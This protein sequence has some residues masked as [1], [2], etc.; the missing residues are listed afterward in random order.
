MYKTHAIIE[1]DSAKRNR[2]D[3]NN[4]GIILSKNIKFNPERQY[5]VRTENARI[6]ISFYAFNSTNNVFQVEE[7]NGATQTIITATVP[8]G[9]YTIGEL[10]LEVENQLDA[11]T[12]QTNDYTFTQDTITGK[13]SISYTGGSTAITIQQS[14]TSTLNPALGFTDTQTLTVGPSTNLIGANFVILQQT[15]YVSIETTIGTSNYYAQIEQADGTIRTLQKSVGLKVPITQLRG[16][17]EFYQNHDGPKIQIHPYDKL[18]DFK[19][20]LKD[21]NEVLLDTNGI[22]Y[23]FDLVFYEV[24]GI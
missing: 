5:F 15:R 11:A 13:T 14:S 6:P 3:I 21:N 16:N 18:H 4:A 10:L 12:T 8:P 17:V 19:V 2:G 9:N 20:Q 7:D 1:F 24:R 22:D 23:S